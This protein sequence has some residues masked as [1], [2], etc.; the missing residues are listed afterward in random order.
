[1]TSSNINNYENLTEL[2]V[3]KCHYNSN[4]LSPFVATGLIVG[5][6]LTTATVLSPKIRKVTLPLA[7]FAFKQQIKTLAGL[8]LLYISTSIASSTDESTH[9]L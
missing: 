1:M 9:Y 2:S 5:S 6:A 7:K 8:G 4:N 3:K